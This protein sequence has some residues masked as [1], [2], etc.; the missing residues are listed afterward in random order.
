MN[1]TIISKEVNNINKSFMEEIADIIIKEN[2]KIISEFNEIANM[3][4]NNIAY[5]IEIMEYCDALGEESDVI[6][7]RSTVRDMVIDIFDNLLI[8]SYYNDST[9][10]TTESIADDDYEF[11]ID[12]LF[13][14]ILT[15][16]ERIMDESDYEELIGSYYTT[17]IK[18]P[19]ASGT[20]NH[21]IL[22]IKNE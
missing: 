11:D 9:I 13:E 4:L 12:M 14:Y 10:V 15:N 8:E 5:N 6:S 7:Y 20:T 21:R 17:H 2:K 18:Y 16:L 19:S 1:N 3:V 22:F